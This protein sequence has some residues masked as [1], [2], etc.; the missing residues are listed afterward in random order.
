MHRDIGRRRVWAVALHGITCEEC[1]R[2]PSWKLCR[3]N[4]VMLDGLSF[5]WR[6]SSRLVVAENVRLRRGV[7]LARWERGHLQFVAPCSA[8]SNLRLDRRP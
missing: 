2:R 6:R 7:K 5:E 8:W 4:K 1:W 3:L